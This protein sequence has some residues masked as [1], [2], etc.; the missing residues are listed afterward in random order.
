VLLLDS[1][2]FYWLLTEPGRLGEKAKDRVR[3][4]S[5]VYVSSITVLE[6]TIKALKA[7]LPELDFPGAISDAGLESLPFVESAAGAIRQFPQ[8]IGHDPFDR[9]LLGQAVVHRLEFLT[10]DRTLL[11][12]GENWIFDIGE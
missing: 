7:K 8:L 9:A 2:A 1:N 11:G 4:A 5:K 10:A 6:L 12:L 3:N